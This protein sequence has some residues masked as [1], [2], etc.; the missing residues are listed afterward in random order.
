MNKRVLFSTALLA[1][2]GGPAAFAQAT[3]WTDVNLGANAEAL[4]TRDFDMPTQDV[5]WGV[6]YDGTGTAGV[7]S[8]D[9]FLSTDG[10]MSWQVNTIATTNSAT[11]ALVNV[12]ALDGSTA[13]VGAYDDAAGGGG[14]VFKTTDGGNTWSELTLPAMAF[15]NFV[16]MFNA[17]EGMIMS[18]PAGSSTAFQLFRTTDAGV[19]WTRVPVANVPASRNGDFG[20][21]NQYSAVGDHIWFTTILGDIYHSMDKGVMWTKHNT[22]FVGT[23][24]SFAIRDVE[25]SDANNGLISGQAANTI[26]RTTDGGMTWTAVVQAADADAFGDDIAHIPGVPG[27]YVTTG[28]NFNEATGTAVTYDN[29]A[30][31]MELD[32]GQQRTAVIFFDA[33]HGW[34]G[35]FTQAAGV[36]GVIQYTGDP[37]LAVRNE[38]VREASAAYPNPTTGALRLA[39]ADPR[40]IVTVY[41]QAGRVT[42]RQPVGT[43]ATLDLSAQPAGLYQLVFTGGKVARTT[44]V[45]V[46]R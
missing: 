3:P 19:T 29:G 14:L 22:G 30:T 25:F 35:T 23:S 42:L 32:S 46:T 6:Q 5:I 37:L 17:N 40:E 12:S 13:V 8:Q 43:A 10:G 7:V 4:G 1:V 41:D 11:A 21:V 45:A 31:W 2:L 44:R 9:M 24:M 15:L 34:A 39:G 36:G 20:L 28:V 38:I 33:T 26:R 18:D 16:H 27:A